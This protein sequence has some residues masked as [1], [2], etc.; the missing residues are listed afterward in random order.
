MSVPPFHTSER[1]TPPVSPNQSTDFTCVFCRIVAG[2]A[3]AK[4]VRSW[5]D[6]V[7]IVP[8][9]P[10]ADG[11]LLVIPRI[12]VP[13]ATAN[14]DVTAAAFRRAAQIMPY[15]SNLITSA[16]KEATQSVSHLH[17]HVVPRATGDGLAL[18]WTRGLA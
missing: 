6:A 14:P 7:A 13:D 3:P 12:H 2:Q 11:H 5:H 9:G 15:P 16:G 1:E 10:V 8:L 18:P 4:I 17:V